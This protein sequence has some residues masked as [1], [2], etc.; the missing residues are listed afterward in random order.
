M[1]QLG[2][3]RPGR[4]LNPLLLKVLALSVAISYLCGCCYRTATCEP[5]IM[6]QTTKPLRYIRTHFEWEEYVY[7]HFDVKPARGDR[8]LRIIC[9][10]CEDPDQKCYVNPD[11]KVFN[12]FH[13]EFSSKKF[14]AISFVSKTEGISKLQAIKKILAE[15]QVT[16]P[17]GNAFETTVTDR[18]YGGQNMKKKKH[19]LRAIDGLPAPCKLMEEKDKEAWPFFS[20]LFGRGLTLEEIIDMRVHYVPDS[21][22]FLYDGDGALKGDIGRRIIWPIYG[23]D[24]ELISWNSREVEKVTDLKYL[25]CPDS[26]INFTL[27]PYSKPYGDTVV[28]VEGILDAYAIRR[29]HEVS[30][31]ATFGKS[32]SEEQMQLLRA[33]GVQ[34]VVLFWDKKDAMKEMKATVENL[35][36]H[37]ETYVAA[38]DN[39][40]KDK[41]CGDT[42]LMEDGI[43]ILQEAL[44][45]IDVYSLEY[46]KWRLVNE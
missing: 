7:D 38:Q 2:H 42:L 33:W 6:N 28:L 16:T 32:V 13:C 40:Q 9:P 19:I 25:N 20:Y 21:V 27:W 4:L 35:K 41:D 11:K 26:D 5:I 18:I 46:D 36:V 30:G 23:G 14:D 1:V 43:E 12:C 44:K 15:L 34:K 29:I 8:E 3:P 37:F 31:Y 17:V 45:P 39:M 10:N 24:N 22:H